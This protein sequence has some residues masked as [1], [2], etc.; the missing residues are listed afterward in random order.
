MNSGDDKFIDH[1]EL[2]GGFLQLTNDD[3][4]KEVI[5]QLPLAE[6]KKALQ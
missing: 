3:N 5:A 6:L 2:N 4:P 1:I